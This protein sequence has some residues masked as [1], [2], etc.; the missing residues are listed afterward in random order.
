MDVL[1]TGGSGF[2]G[3]NLVKKLKE[4]KYNV[5]NL[6]IRNGPDCDVCY[7]PR[8][9]FFMTHQDIVF[10]LAN[11]PAH[12][13]SI[14]SPRDIIYNNYH[15]TLNIAEA[16]R[17]SGRCNKI[18][19]LSSFAVYGSQPT[20]WTESTP[21]QA[22]TPYGLCKIQ[23]EELLRNYHE[24]Y[25]IAVI[26]IRPTNVFG[27]HEELHQPLQVIPRWLDAFKN[28]SILTVY[29]GR[30]FRDFT[31]VDDVVEGIIKSSEKSGFRIYNLCSGKAVYLKELAEYISKDIF[32]KDLPEYETEQWSGSYAKA[33][34]EFGWRPTKTI[35]E[36]I[37]ERKRA[38]KSEKTNAK[39]R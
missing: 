1:V 20:P 24:W 5:Q 10:H 35:W 23:C 25:G 22:T 4:K 21:V 19:F 7:F 31:Y 9:Y 28:Y 32:V 39:P 33:M 36:W 15:A 29:G 38:I 30:T 17:Q 27:E 6:D 14:E 18:V 2:I 13:L 8:I 37:D 34:K 12:R 26:I 11:I 16:V 3:K